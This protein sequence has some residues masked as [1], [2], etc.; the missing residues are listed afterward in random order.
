MRENKRTGT[1]LMKF[2]R[3]EGKTWTKPVDTPWGLP[4]IATM[5]FDRPMGGS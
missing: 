2:S 4:G 5:A 3:D 1:S